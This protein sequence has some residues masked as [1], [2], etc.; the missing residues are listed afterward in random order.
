MGTCKVAGGVQRVGTCKVAGGS[1]RVGTCKVVG[2]SQR[3]GLQRVGGHLEGCRWNSHGWALTSFFT[4]HRLRFL[5]K[6]KRS[7]FVFYRNQNEV[8]RP[9]HSSLRF[10]DFASCFTKSPNIDYLGCIQ[11]ITTATNQF[12]YIVIK[13][14]TSSHL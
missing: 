3:V 1:Q 6:H 9:L 13:L 10:V 11:D 4:I 7:D 14:M 5:Q 2:G 12:D 8:P